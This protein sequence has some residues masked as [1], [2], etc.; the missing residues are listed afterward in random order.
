MTRVW[1]DQ[2][3]TFTDVLTLEDDGRVRVDKIWSDTADLEAL[4]AADPAPRR[5][6]TV[7]TN[8]LLERTGAPVLLLT[9]TGFGDMPWLGDQTRPR[10]FD[11]TVGRAPPLCTGVVE[12]QGRIAASGEVLAPATVDLP[13]LRQWHAQ[14][15]DA[16]AIVLV[17]GPLHPESERALGAACAEVGFRTISL[18]HEVAPSQGFLSRLQTT[19]VDAAL[20]PLLPQAPGLYMCSDGALAKQEE[21]RGCRAVLSG[22]AG[23]VVATADLAA[24]AKVG[25]AFGLDMGGTSTDVCRVDG[26]PE[27]TSHLTIGGM[28]IRVPAVQLETVAAGGGSLL[29]LQGGVM[30][31]GPRSAGAH[32]GPAAYGR[33]GPATLTDAATV[34]GHLPNFPEV[35]GPSRDAPLNPTA[36]KM[37]IDGLGLDLSTEAAAE[38]FARVAAEAAARAV[39]SLAAARGV[40]PSN[41]ALIAFGGAGPGHGCAVAEAL[42]IQTVIV[43]R[44]AGAFS[45]VGVGCARRQVEVAVPVRT[46]ILAALKSVSLPFSGDTRVRLA[47]RHV[48]TDSI[49]EIEIDPALPGLSEPGLPP[50][51]IREFSDAHLRCFGFTRPEH[52]VEPVE[53]RIRVSEPPLDLPKMALASGE[54]HRSSVEAW[55]DGWR[56]V[57][58]MAMEHAD[59]LTGPALLTGVG[60]TVVVAPGWTV[61]VH[62]TYLQLVTTE[63]RHPDLGTEAHPVHTAIFGSRVMAIAE[64]MGQRLARLARSVSIRERQDFSCAVFDAHGQ[65]VANAPH[66]P[67]HLGAMGE[68]VR[69]LLRR[70]G[71]TLEPGQAWASNDPYAGGTHLPDITVTRPVF[72]QA[73]LVAFVACRGHHIDVGGI[74]PGSMPPHATHIEE[75]GFRLDQVLLAEGDRMH[76]PDLPG[77]RQPRDVL[78]DLEAQVAACTAG[79][80]RLRSLLTSVGPTI[81]SA[82][83]GHLQDQGERAVRAVLQRMAGH[84]H[85]AE[86]LDDGTRIE[87]Q[88]EVQ[89]S[90]AAIHIQAPAHPGNL[91]APRAVAHAVVLYVFRSLVDEELPILNEGTLR[92]IH[93]T[94]SPGGL[95]D[96]QAPAAVAGG[97][98][99]TSQRLVDALLAALGMQAGSQ[100]TMNNLTVG[101]SQGAFY[102][103]IAGGAGAGPGFDGPCAI[104]IHMT[105]T[106]ATDVEVLEARFPIR[107]R[108]WQLRRDSGGPGAWRGG[109]GVIKEWEFLDRAEVAILAGRRNAGAPGHAGGGDGAP[110]MDSRRIDGE[111][112]AAPTL[113][114]AEA[115]E[116]LRVCTPGGGGWGRPN[117]AR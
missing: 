93:I 81:F 2:G 76:P 9:T 89:D 47:A 114:V 56:E 101:T 82:Q 79:A 58:L 48:G 29:T 115:G 17:H 92:P 13:Q 42:G 16:V 78:A 100:G 72:D 104:Q 105:N 20:T 22:P 33:G 73:T 41:H 36:A 8:A 31:V 68:T 25:P 83:L 107:I 109:D 84:H 102:E 7:A 30:Q 18:G 23:G 43:P 46:H 53:L 6:S 66:V 21:W 91:N 37:A 94:L 24:L 75:E 113:W 59:G 74:S 86:T 44:L 85:A 28:R 111:W 70:H 98:V 34:L 4:G 69:D 63:T 80:E 19:I 108:R 110:G 77:C 117:G 26:A 51:L 27:R 32:P 12:V 96:P 116:V 71:P 3:G 57:P 64:Q 11:R 38:G 50:A 52:E 65:L 10:L 15:V 97:N 87:V 45:A 35:C 60:T 103:T 99:E 67:V 1:M 62:P 14:G 5:G 61:H 88:V 90:A 54:S 95:F 106:R 49:L 112:G 40:N 55:F 39:R